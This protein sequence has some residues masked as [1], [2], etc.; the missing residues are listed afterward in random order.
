MHQAIGSIVKSASPLDDK[1]QAFFRQC[2]VSRLTGEV[3]ASVLSHK[4][5]AYVR[6]SKLLMKQ[7][8]RFRKWTTK[9]RDTTLVPTWTVTA[10]IRPYPAKAPS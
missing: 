7:N 5:L 10:L 9:L 3:E 8:L 6:A 1:F 2:L 4:Y